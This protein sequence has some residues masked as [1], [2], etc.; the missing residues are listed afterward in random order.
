MSLRHS[1]RSSRLGFT[2]IELLIAAAILGILLGMV[3]PAMVQALNVRRTQEVRLD[4]QQN[5]RNGMQMLAQDARTASLLHVWNQTP[6]DAGVACSSN[7]QVALVSV[8]GAMTQVPEP[9][10]DSFNRRFTR[11]CDASDFAVGDLVVLVNGDQHELMEVTG[12]PRQANSEQPCSG[13]LLP[14][15]G[16]VNHDND[17]IRGQWTANAYVLGAQIITWTLQPDPIDPTRTVLYRRTGLGTGGAQTGV[18]AFGVSGLTVSY[19]V[20]LDPTSKLVFY[21]TLQEAA[22]ALGNPYTADPQVSGTFVGGLVR[23]LRIQLD[24]TSS[25]SERPGGAPATFSLTQTVDLRR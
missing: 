9:P 19:G 4:L 23:A 25:S 3:G 20:P 16:R 17:R 13:E 14:N 10:G 15:F 5:L 21:D 7:E 12:I 18:V 6:C 22:T 11:V 1:S 2:L 8:V 24:G